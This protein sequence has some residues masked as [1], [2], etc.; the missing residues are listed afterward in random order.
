VVDYNYGPKTDAKHCLCKHKKII[1][2]K[3]IFHSSKLLIAD[4]IDSKIFCLLHWHLNLFYSTLNLKK[5]FVSMFFAKIFN[6][7]LQTNFWK[8]SFDI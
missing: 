3:C 1:H 4:L 8:Y 7:K 2:Q 6:T 5:H